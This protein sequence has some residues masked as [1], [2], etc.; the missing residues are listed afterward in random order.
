KFGLTYMFISHN[1]AVVRHMASRVGVMY[2]GRIVEIAEGRELFTLA[3]SEEEAQQLAE[4]YGIELVEFGNGVAT[5]HTEEPPAE[6]V[7][8]GQANGWPLIEV[9]YLNQLHVD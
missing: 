4:L 1:L 7:A 8:R 6:V 3:D 2:L 9:N 5:F